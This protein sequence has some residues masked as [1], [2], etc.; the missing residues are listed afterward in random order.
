MRVATARQLQAYDLALVQAGYAMETLVHMASDLLLPH[1]MAYD[2]IVI[3]CGNGNNGSDG[4][5]LAL[6]LQSMGKQVQVVLVSDSPR[7]GAL[8][9]TL[10]Q[11]V[12]DAHIP[13][14]NVAEMTAISKGA[15]VVDAMLGFGFVGTPRAN[16]LQAIALVNG[17]QGQVLSVDIPSGFHCDDFQSDAPMVMADKTLTFVCKK[18]GFLNE[19]AHSYLGELVVAPLPVIDP[20]LTPPLAILFDEDM[21]QDTLKPRDYTSYKGKNGH[22]LLC[23]GSQA[24]MGAGL[25]STK[26]CVYSGCGL[27][28]WCGAV[29]LGQMMVANTPELIAIAPEKLAEKVEGKTAMLIGSGLGLTED[30]ETLLHFVLTQ[31]TLPLVID[32][33]GLTLLARNPQLLELARG[34]AILTPHLGEFHRFVPQEGDLVTQALAFAKSH[35]VVLVLKGPATIVTDGEVIFRTTTGNRRMATA[36]SGDVL[37]GVV[38]ALLAGAYTSMEAANLAVYLHGAAGDALAKTHYTAIPSLVIEQIPQ[39][40][41][42]L[43]V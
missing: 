42:Q 13:R 30:S 9:E 35:G 17:T 34:R 19:E 5:S 33:D 7:R 41:H 12:A 11:R 10:L 14:V 25:L 8:N 39:V 31:T 29:E 27:T 38:V 22:A 28:T 21:A 37:A 6:K 32:G 1:C 15:L 36:G 26:A 2:P 43:T 40:M 20:E 4:L 3:F 16:T 23:T 24:Y 18:Q